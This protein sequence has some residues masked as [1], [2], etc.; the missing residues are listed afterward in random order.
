[1]PVNDLSSQKL[2]ELA[3]FRPEGARVLSLFLSLEP[4]EFATGSARAT[5]MQSVLDEADRQVRESDSLSHQEK[6]ALREDV[7]RLRGYFKRNV[8]LKGAHGLAIYA[9]GPAGLFEVLKLPRPVELR[10]VIDDSPFVE[11]LADLGRRGT[12]CVVLV[13]RKVGRML[14]GTPD[15]L[16]ELPPIEDDVHGQHDQGGWSQARYQ[17]SVENEVH[18]HLRRTTDLAFRRFKRTQFERLLVGGPEEIVAAFEERLHPYL[19]ERLAGR[20]DVDVE[21]TSVDHVRRAVAPVIEEH[22]RT[23]ERQALDRIVEGA[24]SGGRGAAGL[25]SVLTALN[26]RRVETLVLA[27]GVSEPGVTCPQ[28]GWV[29]PDGESSCPL[30]GTALERRENVVESAVELALMQSADVLVAR[31]HGDELRERGSIGAVLRF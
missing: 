4:S 17:R 20:V 14:L 22:D 27:E 11:P 31:H 1:M 8:D 26:E 10:A 21:N 18:Q 5:E 6:R 19:R 28:C 7:E 30:D 3:E 29:G 2:R 12:W 15:Q 9:C 13:N 25:E 24:S 16:E 23:R